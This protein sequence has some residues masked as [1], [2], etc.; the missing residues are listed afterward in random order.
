MHQLLHLITTR[1]QLLAAHAEAYAALAS[2]EFP[3]IGAAWKR[4]ALLDALALCA[5]GVA[6][7]LAGVALMLWAS[8]PAVPAQASWVL[9][10]IPCLP[11]ALAAWFAAAARS[12]SGRD[13]LAN[14]REQVQADLRL[15]REVA[16]R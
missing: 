14:L 4:R 13:A 9:I 11:L 3:R 10:G 5:V 15:L 7:V 1:P 12:G 16:A 2:A 6:A 8:L